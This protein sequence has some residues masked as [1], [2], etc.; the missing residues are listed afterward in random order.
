ML[1]IKIAAIAV[2]ASAG[3]LIPATV[4]TAAPQGVWTNN[5]ARNAIIRHES[6]GN[7][8]AV[9]P[10]SGTTG[11]YQCMPSVHACPRLGDVAGQHRWGEAYMKGRYGTWSN[12]L[13]FWNSHNYW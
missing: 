10:V 7:P 9:N 4:S 3:I 2:M 5:A 12:A 6:S 13:A 8:Y 11:L 1:K